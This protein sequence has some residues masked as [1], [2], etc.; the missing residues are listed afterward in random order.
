MVFE[1]QITDLEL[2]KAYFRACVRPKIAAA[3][4]KEELGKPMSVRRV[5]E[6]MQEL[7]KKGKL[8]DFL[9]ENEV[10]ELLAEAHTA[11]EVNDFVKNGLIQS[12]M[13]GSTWVFWINDIKE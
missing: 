12:E 4:V 1:E 9:S 10:N 11:E 8:T 13:Q 2:L 5:K 7:T 3:Q 6:R